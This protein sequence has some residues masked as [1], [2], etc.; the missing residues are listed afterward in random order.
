[1][2]SRVDGILVHC[3]N[4]ARPQKLSGISPLSDGHQHYNS[5]QI[6]CAV[7]ER[8]DARN[9][10]RVTLA[11]P[12]DSRKKSPEPT[13][14]GVDVIAFSGKHSSSTCPESC[15][16]LSSGSTNGVHLTARPM[17]IRHT[18]PLP[19]G[20]PIKKLFGLMSR[21]TYPILWRASR[22]LSICKG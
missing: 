22:R 11:N 6:V 14:I 20:P 17:S 10:L 16:D 3:P 7:C 5:L 15:T 9:R 1:M 13:S 4:Q 19:P 21:C 18:G 12:K 2:S 8:S